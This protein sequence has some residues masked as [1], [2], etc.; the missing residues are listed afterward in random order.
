MS[1]RGEHEADAVRPDSRSRRF[2][3]EMA[4]ATRL[5]AAQQGLEVGPSEAVAPGL[6]AAYRRRHPR[7]GG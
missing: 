7:P 6:V 1:T 5:W 3:R 2:D 4:E